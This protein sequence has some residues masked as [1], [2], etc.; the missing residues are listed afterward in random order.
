MEVMQE[1]TCVKC[2]AKYPLGSKHVCPECGSTQYTIAYDAGIED[3][4]KDIEK[5]Y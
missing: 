3:Y 1:Y 5:T 4:F 2:E